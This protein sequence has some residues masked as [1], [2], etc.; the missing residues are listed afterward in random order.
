V[1]RGVRRLVEIVHEQL[2]SGEMRVESRNHVAAAVSQ[3]GWVLRWLSCDVLTVSR[4]IQTKRW[5]DELQRPLCKQC[6]E[7][8]DVCTQKPWFGPSTETGRPG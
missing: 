3:L 8:E 7:K 4:G 5:D 2:V 6:Q 1:R